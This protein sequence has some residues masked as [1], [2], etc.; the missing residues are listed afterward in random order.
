MSGQRGGDAAYEERLQGIPNGHDRIRWASPLG[1]V[2]GS[3]VVALRI[4]YRVVGL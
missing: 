2:A 4:A 1:T 3:Q